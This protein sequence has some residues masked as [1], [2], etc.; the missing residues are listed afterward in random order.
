MAIVTSLKNQKV[1]ADKCHEAVSFFDRLRGLIGRTKFTPGEAMFFPRCND[2][3]MWFM[4]IPIDVVFVCEENVAGKSAAAAELKDRS[5]VEPKVRILKVTRVCES[6]KP[7]RVLPFHDSRA[8]ETLELPV[9]TV[10]R[11]EIRVG[12]EICIS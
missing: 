11:C 3:H 2:I 12:D 4:R 8:T 7:W 10:E 6:A 1:I 5:Y 9:G